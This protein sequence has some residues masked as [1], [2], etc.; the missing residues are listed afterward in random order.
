MK[1]F[2]L[3]EVY[4][5]IY[6]LAIYIYCSY[7]TVIIRFF[8]YA[9][10][11]NYLERRNWKKNALVYRVEL[12]NFLRREIYCDL[13]F[14]CTSENVFYNL[15]FPFDNCILQFKFSFRYNLNFP[16]DHRVLILLCH[17]RVF[18]YR[19]ASSRHSHFIYN[20]Y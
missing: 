4:I 19:L 2:F 15:N 10:S 1:T 17:L 20:S 9:C 3:R 7:I 5:Y 13:L 8:I 14:F 11:R 16:F 18:H 12:F 6:I